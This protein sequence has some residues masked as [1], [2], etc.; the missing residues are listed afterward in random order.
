M[1]S[2]LYDLAFVGH[3]TR[4]TIVR[5][6][7]EATLPGGAFYHGSHVA[8]AMGLSAAVVTRLAA[9]DEP[10]LDNLRALGIDVFATITP[11]STALRLV[12]PGD[13]PDQRALHAT[14]FAGAL[15]PA[16]VAP[17][18]ARA[19]LCGASRRGELP[20]ETIQTLAAKGGMLALDL[21]GYLRTVQDGILTLAPWPEAR[22]YLKLVTVLKG[23]LVEAAYL[24]GQQEEA[25]AARALARLGPAEVV[26]TSSWGV[27]VCAGRQVYQGPWHGQNLSG[28]TGRGDTCLA[29]YVAQRLSGGPEEACIWAA[30]VTSLKMETPGPF[31][32]PLSAVYDL[33]AQAY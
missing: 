2:K 12:Y 33:I 4:D 26:L 8:A 18:D 28:R 21:Q 7:E 11:Q 25:P 9:E 29:A 32:R 13:D 22:S 16:E 3:F 27:T 31:R 30:A 23:D 10:Y 6:G 15:L 14:G 20:L 17:I 24:T 19:F 5:G 1:S